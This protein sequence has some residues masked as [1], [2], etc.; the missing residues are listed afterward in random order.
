MKKK[1]FTLIELLVVIAIIAILAGM[2]LPALSKAR[3]KAKTINC[4]GN[5][6]QL[7][8]AAAMY[9]QD[10]E[11]W[12]PLNQI[13]STVNQNM[14]WR[15]E[16]SKYIYGSAVTDNTDRMIKTGAYACP[17]FENPTSLT[18]WDGGYGWN[19]QYLGHQ[20]VDATRYRRKVQQ[21]KQP[22]NT[23]MI[24]DSNDIWEDSGKEARLALLIYPSSVIITPTGVGNRHNGAINITW[25]DGHV[26]LERQAK[27]INGLNGDIDWYYRDDK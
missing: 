13:S 5:L 10:W 16:L 9:T 8:T 23:V 21:V 17:S 25:A 6:K 19:Y 15:M 27:L 26:T 3:E 14:E 24:G 2:L 7:G 20:Q 12:L 11:D 22:S 4:A 1:N 18:Q